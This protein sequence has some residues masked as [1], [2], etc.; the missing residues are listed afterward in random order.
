MRTPAGGAVLDVSVLR[1]HVFTNQDEAESSVFVLF[2]QAKVEE[3]TAELQVYN[4]LK[5]RVE[6]STFK[7]DLQRNIQVCV[8][9]CVFT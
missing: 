9:V 3:L 8:C 7:K 1:F 4:E 6:E 5:R 2:L